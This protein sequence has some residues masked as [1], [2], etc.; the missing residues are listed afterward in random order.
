VEKDGFKLINGRKIKIKRIPVGALPD[1]V[2]ACDKIVD[3]WYDHTHQCLKGI[4]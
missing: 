3:K 2:H 4:L 1:G